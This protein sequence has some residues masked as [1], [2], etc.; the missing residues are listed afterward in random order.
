M[1]LCSIC[2]TI[3][4]LKCQT[5]TV[6]FDGLS[7]SFHVPDSTIVCRAFYAKGPSC[8]KEDVDLSPER[9][10]AAVT[11]RTVNWMRLWTDSQFSCVAVM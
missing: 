9:E 1:H 10:Q 8:E 2:N 6:S 7:E 11:V 3:G 5:K 4:A